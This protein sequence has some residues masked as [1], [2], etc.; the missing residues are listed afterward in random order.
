[1][2]QLNSEILRQFESQGLAIDEG[3]AVDARLVRSASH[4]LSNE[5][6]KKGRWLRPVGN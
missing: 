1:M 3:A 5:Q 6:L 4:A 2:D